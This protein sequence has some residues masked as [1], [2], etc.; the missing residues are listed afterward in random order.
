MTPLALN[1]APVN[2][3][4]PIVTF[5]S[6]LFVKVTFNV[7]LF[8]SFTLPKFRLVG[9][10]ASSCVAGAPVPLNETARG[11]IAPLLTRETAPVTVAAE[12]GAN[13][14][15]KVVL[16][17]AAIVAGVARPLRLKPVP[18]AVA[19]DIVTLAVPVFFSVMVCELLLPMTTLPKLTL[20]GVAVSWP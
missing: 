5:E 18:E 3:K 14:A 10:A 1:P 13:A 17:P 6:P 7:L 12:V 2:V 11:E 15:L 19:A 20:D 16:A 8:P 4:P 9:L